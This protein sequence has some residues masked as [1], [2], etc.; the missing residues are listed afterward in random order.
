M[1]DSS[2]PDKTS[3]IEQANVTATLPSG[4]A[5]P[6]KTPFVEE[7]NVA[8]PLSSAVVSSESLPVTCQANETEPFSSAAVNSEVEATPGTDKIIPAVDANIQEK[9]AVVIQSAARRFLV[10]L[11]DS[12]N[13]L[14]YLISTFVTLLIIF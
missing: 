14:G 9:V 12:D 10:R 4:V 8:A 1:K 11:Q 6:E 13:F 5:N 3:I 2:V 7:T